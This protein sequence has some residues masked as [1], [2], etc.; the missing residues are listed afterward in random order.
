MATSTTTRPG[1]SDSVSHEIAQRAVLRSVN[2][3]NGETTKTY[4]EMTSDEVDAAI[5]TAHDRFATW[6]R[7]PFTA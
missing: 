7:V 6:R 1:E 4:T 2:P 3:Y 5:A